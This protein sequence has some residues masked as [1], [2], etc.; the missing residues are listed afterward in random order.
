MTTHRSMAPTRHGTLPAGPGGSRGALAAAVAARIAGAGLLGTAAGI[1]LH[2]W[3]LGYRYIETIGPLFLANGV[4]G[5]GLG[6]AVLGAPR[7]LRA[8]AAAAGAAFL[9]GSLVALGLSLGPGLFGFEEISSA[10]LV[11]ETWAVEGA[12]TAVLTGLA[13]VD[14]VRWY[15]RRRSSHG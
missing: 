5:I 8:V 13:A 3:K 12:G 14:I 1:H 11:T 15:R 10:P 9:A 6:L 4:L 7:R 2:L